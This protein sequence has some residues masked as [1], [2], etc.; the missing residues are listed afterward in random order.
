MLC[1]EVM[2]VHTKGTD[3][4]REKNVELFVNLV[5]RNHWAF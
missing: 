4:L 2:A 5:A 3:E 1:R